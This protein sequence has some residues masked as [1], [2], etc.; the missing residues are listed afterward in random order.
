MAEAHPW[1]TWHGTDL[2]GCGVRGWC[3]SRA[4]IGAPVNGAL[5]ENALLAAVMGF[6]NGVAF[7]AV[8][9]IAEGRRTFEEMS[10]WRFAGWGVVVGLVVSLL[11]GGGFLV[12]F[13]LLGAGCAAGSLAVARRA[14]P[15]LE[16]GKGVGLLEGESPNPLT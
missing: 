5:F 15:L 12:F 16:P 6:I 10:L 11:T 1:L 14:D 2:G 9:R 4:P 13:T 8:L 3:R 7:S